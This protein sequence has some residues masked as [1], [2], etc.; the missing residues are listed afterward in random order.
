[1]VSFFTFLVSVGIRVGATVITICG[2]SSLALLQVY[3]CSHQ[4]YRRVL[5]KL[6]HISA[7]NWLI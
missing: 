5:L 1:M 4:F 6:L 3:T 2:E 7:T